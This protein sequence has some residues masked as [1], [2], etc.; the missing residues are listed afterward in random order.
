MRLAAVLLALLLA[1]PLAAA[2]QRDVRVTLAS[3][4]DGTMYMDPALVEVDA[5]D[6]VRLLVLNE[7]PMQHDLVIL[8]Y[9]LFDVEVEVGP[10]G[11]GETTFTADKAGNFTMI[12]EIGDHRARGQEG[13]FRVLGESTR[14]APVSGWAAPFALLIVA[15]AA[16]RRRAG[17]P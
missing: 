2:A 10:R 15:L 9:G 3:R 12:C 1:A 8:D 4:P 7:D 16:G 13:T 5:G 17:P 6:E 14:D 11:S